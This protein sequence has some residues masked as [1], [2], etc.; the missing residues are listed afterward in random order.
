[1]VCL[2]IP[3]LTIRSMEETYGKDL[4]YHEKD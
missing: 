4:N 3:L 1:V 2:G